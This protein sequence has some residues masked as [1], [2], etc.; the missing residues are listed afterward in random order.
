MSGDLPL[1]SASLAGMAYQRLRGEI[2]RAELAPGQKLHI[3]DLADRYGTG[4]TPVREALNRLFR[5]GLVEHGEQRGF[6]VTGISESHLDELTRTRQWLYEVGL[7][8]SIEHGDAAWEEAIIVSYHRMAKF[9]AAQQSPERDSAHRHF[10][11]TLIAACRSRWLIEFSEQL[12]D[13]AERY[14]HV[15]RLSN[16]RLVVRK[17]DEHKA[18]MEAVL[19]RH[20]SQAVSLLS[21]H[22]TRTAQL[23]RGKCA[24]LGMSAEGKV[25]NPD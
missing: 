18:M 1:T 15:A 10:H 21:A 22:V 13:A 4:V 7:R 11:S 9:N 14:R 3:K 20:T 5:D 12:F 6:S 16:H 8:E 17:G 19:S 24:E 23:V 25:R 2:I